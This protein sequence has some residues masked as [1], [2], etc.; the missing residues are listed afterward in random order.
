R[1]AHEEIVVAKLRDQPV[2]LLGFGV[3]GLGLARG[4]RGE[5][6]QGEQRTVHEGPPQG[7][8]DQPFSCFRFDAISASSAFC[9][10]ANFFVPSSISTAS[11][12]CQS[13]FFSISSRTALGGNLSTCRVKVLPLLATASLV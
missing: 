1:L 12:F 4:Q 5:P 3:V 13:T 2:D 7:G 6:E 10:S 11:S 8:D 9:G